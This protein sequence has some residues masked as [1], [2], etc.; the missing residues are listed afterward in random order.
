[1]DFFQRE[2]LEASELG[3]FE[4]AEITDI[5][6]VD[7]E[8]LESIL[9]S[10]LFASDRPVSM[11]SI[12][13]VFK[14]TN[15]KTEQIRKALDFLVVE[16]AGGKRGVILEEIQGGYQLRTKVENMNFIKRTLKAR[17][18]KVSGPA[19]EVLSVVAYKQPVVKYEIDEIR[20][21]ESGHLLRA[22]MEKGLVQFQGKS[23][24]PGKPMQYA[25]TRKFLEIFSLRNLKELPTLSQIDELL[26]EG[27][28]AEEAAPK[29]TLSTITD[30]M[31]ES[32]ANS[33][34]VGEEELN[35]I[36]DQLDQIST[37][38]DFF[39]EEKRRQKEKK[40]E[41]KALSLREALM[42][43]E[44]ISTRDM[45][46][47]INFDAEKEAARNAPPPP[48]V[49]AVVEEEV[50]AVEA[51]E[52]DSEGAEEGAE[53]RESWETADSDESEDSDED[54]SDDLAYS[55]SDDDDEDDEDDDEEDSEG[56]SEP[57]R[58]ME[59]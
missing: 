36:V 49:A 6:M 58:E 32:I 30:S 41:E 52:E 21:V 34:S 13:E 1:M 17:Q 57:E 54:E 53:D 37:S 44:K 7:A 27:I 48:P 2:E 15:I 26:P 33:Y 24:L 14:G 11:A 22:L 3:G 31:S 42:V 9:E 47:L 18:F 38:S 39:E 35:K 5:E 51:S 50:V 8:K 40:D 25:T 12:K 46:W 19:L 16:Y 20:G 10:I 59:L 55:A 4:S 28:D 56:S 23:E 43:G 29:P 45:K